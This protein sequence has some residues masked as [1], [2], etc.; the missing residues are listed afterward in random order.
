[1]SS[2]ES[3]RPQE[4]AD[5]CVWFP[6]FSNLMDRLLTEAPDEYV[7][8]SV[9]AVNKDRTTSASIV[10][11]MKTHNGVHLG[12]LQCFFPRRDSPASIGFDR[13]SSIVGDHLTLEVNR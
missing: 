4:G 9:K 6:G 8:Y 13:W 3:A 12:T 7:S 1:M 2:L 5:Y 11:D 10:F